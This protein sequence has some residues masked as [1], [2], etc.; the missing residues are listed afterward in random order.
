MS[1][2]SSDHAFVWKRR[3]IKSI[4]YY[5]LWVSQVVISVCGPEAAKEAL[6]N[7]DLDGRPSLDNLKARTYGQR[8]GLMF[9]DGEFWRHQRR[10]TLRHLRDF[11]FGKTSMEHIMNEE[12]EE[13][14]AEMRTKSEADSGRIVDFQGLFNIPVTN[15]LWAIV[16]GER[17]RRD[18]IRFRRLL[19]NL[20][21]FMRAGNILRSSVNVPPV[22]YRLMPSLKKYFGANS[23]LF[24]P[25]IHFFEVI[26][27]QN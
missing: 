27:L 21:I 14:L 13:T 12:I 1:V 4:H 15:M 16:A 25:L 18:D 19:N 26:Q 2:S 5:Y 8:L 24:E 3:Y 6:Q 22:I 20:E 17:F 10:F 9:T 7:K 11:G 23:E